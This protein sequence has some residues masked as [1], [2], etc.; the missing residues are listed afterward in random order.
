MNYY[1]ISIIGSPL[2]PFTYHSLQNINIGTKVQVH[3]KNRVLDGVV[4]ATCNKPAFQTNEVLEVSEF[5]YSLKQIALAKFIAS[6]YICSLGDAF[7]VMMPFTGKV[8]TWAVRHESKKG[9]VKTSLPKSNIVLS[10]KQEKALT[11][12]QQHKVALLFGDTGSGKTEVYMKYFEQIIQEG[13]TSIF[14]MPEISL[15]PQM[16]K[17]LKEHFGDDFVMWHSKLTPLAKKKALAKIY[18][19]EAKIIA[20][21]RSAL[22][23][24]IKDLGLIVVDEE[25]DESYKSSSRPRYNARDLAIYMGK[26]YDVHV[27]LGSATPSLNSYAKFE[28]TRLKGGHFSSL[29]T[30]IY[31]KSPESLSPLITE[32]LQE[33]LQKKEQSIVFLPTRANFK[34]L[35]CQDCGHTIKCAFCSVG[36][37]VHQHSRA[38]KC[39]YCNFTQAIP[40]VCPECHSPNLTSSRLGTAEAV[41]ILQEVLPQARVEQFDRD[42]ITTANKLK[43]ALKR[44]NDKE[45]DILVGTQMLSKGHDYHGVTLAVVLGMDNMLNMSDY[46]AREKALSSLIQVAGR[47]GRAKDAKVIVQTFNEDFFKNYIDN[48]EDFLEE[49]KFFRQELYPPYKKLC[50]ILFAHKKG[51]KAQDEMRKMHDKLLTCKGVEIVGAKKCSIEKVA[52]KYRFEILLRADKSTDIIKAVKASKVDLAEV[53]MDPIEFG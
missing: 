23:L 7:S 25:H 20:G 39:H 8:E 6:Y 43:K 51:A 52:N 36:M 11:F 12:L 15:T 2:E 50:R 35:L 33:V 34:Y 37:S 21:A 53:D 22:F 18:A 38:L 16:S 32:N 10:D 19:G 29:K 26:L 49:E 48:Y 28:H 13:K 42:V 9:E 31:E 24:P 46:R 1:N 14:L 47:S 5:Y 27:V 45:S 41:K 30:F 40:Q 3:V 4:I 44:F 17:R